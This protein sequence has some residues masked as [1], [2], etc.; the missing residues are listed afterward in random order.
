MIELNFTFQ[1]VSPPDIISDISLAQQAQ[2]QLKEDS[3]CETIKGTS[4]FS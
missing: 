3:L 1:T 2:R 4:G